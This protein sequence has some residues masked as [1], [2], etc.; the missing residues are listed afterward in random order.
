MIVL[1]K[2]RITVILMCV[3]MGVFTFSFQVAKLNSQEK[4][5]K[6]EQ[7][8]EINNIS[9]INEIKETTSTPV[10]GR[11]VILDA[12]HGVPDEGAQSSNG[13][14]EAETNLKIALKVQNLLEQSG[15]TVILTRSDE[16]AIYDLDSKTLKQKKISDIHN[17]VKI[18][19]ESSADIFVSIHLNKIPQQ[20]YW[21]WQC[22][23]KDGNEQ[24]T[25]LAK[26]I[27]SNLNEAIQKENNRVAM[28][29][30]NIYIVKK[31]EIPLSIVE[32]GFLSNPEEEKLLLED[33][34]QDKLSW[35]IFNGIME[36]FQN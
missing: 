32:C 14:T 26:V 20:Q 34:Y 25:K 33:E 28:K 19:N 22:F 12:G 7:L 13:T 36:Y 17:R 15:C 8:G 31:V 11:T 5:D 24:S 16:N 23:Y 35:G 2:K 4:L 6:E 30:D 10:S 9:Q 18:G 21:G 1:N 29:I 3:L 27:Q